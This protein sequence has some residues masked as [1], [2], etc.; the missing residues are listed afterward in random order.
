MPAW[1]I[2][3]LVF[4]SGEHLN[5]QHNLTVGTAVMNVQEPFLE[6]QVC[7]P[8]HSV[9]KI[10]ADPRSF[11]L[12]SGG[13]FAVKRHPRSGGP[14]CGGISLEGMCSEDVLFLSALLAE[15]ARAS[16]TSSPR[17]AQPHAGDGKSSRAPLQSLSSTKSSQQSCSEGTAGGYDK[18]SGRFQG[19]SS[20]GGPETWNS[21]GGVVPEMPS[22]PLS[23][24]I[25]VS[26]GSLVGFLVNDLKKCSGVSRSS[27]QF[28]AECSC[29]LCRFSSAVKR[30]V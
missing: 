19:G 24:L 16:N 29:S 8:M 27:I 21:R 1:K 4:T 25:A 3:A 28:M 15:D 2:I 17:P 7:V 30:V 5:R 18:L 26:S 14:Q 6:G 10:R 23:E 11:V 20:T 13:W 9:A 12:S 22:F